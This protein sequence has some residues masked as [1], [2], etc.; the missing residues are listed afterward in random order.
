MV[1]FWTW[2]RTGA[3][4]QPHDPP[5]SQSPG[6]S[7][8][9]EVGDSRFRKPLRREP[10]GMWLPET[11]VDTETLEVLAENGIQFTILAPR[12]AKRVR[13][14]NSSKFE[15]VTGARIDPA[16]AYRAELPSKKRDQLVF[17]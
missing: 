14:R 6:Q 7:H 9:S 3:R 5:A 4:L 12:Q 2:L 13:P 10:E 15:D 11:A 17:L 1:A 8:A 16:R